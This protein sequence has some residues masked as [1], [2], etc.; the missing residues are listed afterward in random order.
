[1]MNISELLDS[2]RQLCFLNEFAINEHT[3]VMV[4]KLGYG[5]RT[6]L[7]ATRQAVTSQAA[8]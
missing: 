8:S 4:M 2:Q 1:M 7:I 5:T 3:C 6:S